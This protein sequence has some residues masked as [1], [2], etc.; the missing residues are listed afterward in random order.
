MKKC[1]VCNYDVHIADKQLT[2]HENDGTFTAYHMS[3]ENRAKH[4]KPCEDCH[5][6]RLFCDE[7]KEE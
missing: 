7:C 3:C 2:R 1:G 5:L 4:V 6:H